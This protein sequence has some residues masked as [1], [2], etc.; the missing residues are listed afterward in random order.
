M[1]QGKLSKN[2]IWYGSKLENGYNVLGANCEHVPAE[3]WIKKQKIN[4]TAY[5]LSFGWVFSFQLDS[6]EKNL[7]TLLGFTFTL[8]GFPTGD[9]TDLL[10]LII[11]LLRRKVAS[12]AILLFP[13]LCVELR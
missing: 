7:T 1:I 2:F 3:H 5:F 8:E 6:V 9:P 10:L 13:V 11:F 4:Q 12:N